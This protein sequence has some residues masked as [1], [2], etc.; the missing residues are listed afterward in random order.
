MEQEVRYSV[1]FTPL[2]ER[3]ACEAPHLLEGLERL[4]T[5]IGAEDFDKYINTLVSLRKVDDLALIIT[6][7]EMNRSI[8]VSRFLPAI[9]ECFAVNYIQVINQ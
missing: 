8:I 2:E 1:P 6:K 5:K 4:K 3:I 7:R 9:K